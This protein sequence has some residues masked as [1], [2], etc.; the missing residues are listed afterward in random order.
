MIPTIFLFFSAQWIWIDIQ[1]LQ[2]APEEKGYRAGHYD[3]WSAK[4]LWVRQSHYSQ[5]VNYINIY[6]I[7]VHA[8]NTCTCHGDRYK[9]NTN[10]LLVENKNAS[11]SLFNWIDVV[12]K[13]NS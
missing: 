4:V 12:M 7:S 13:D 11:Q 10:N 8:Y 3:R 6:N 2:K 1:V 9:E 5:L